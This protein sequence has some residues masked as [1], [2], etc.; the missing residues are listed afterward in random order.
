MK[1]EFKS[2]AKNSN[3]RAPHMLKVKCIYYNDEVSDDVM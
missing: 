2:E 3:E 1:N